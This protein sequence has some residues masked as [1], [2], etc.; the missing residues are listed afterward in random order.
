MQIAE[1]KGK[2]HDQMTF[3][4]RYFLLF[5][6]ELTFT[7]VSIL[8]NIIT[9]AQWEFSHVLGTKFRYLYT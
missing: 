1:D 5:Y 8:V 3:K 9:I 4:K 7:K 2:S 6:T